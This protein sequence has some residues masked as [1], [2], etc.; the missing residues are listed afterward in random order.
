MVFPII[1]VLSAVVGIAGTAASIKAQSD[2]ASAQN[3]AIN[4]QISSNVNAERIRRAN[5]AFQRELIK[6][7]TQVEM[8][9]NRQ[10]FRNNRAQLQ[11]AILQEQLSANADIRQLGIQQQQNEAARLNVAARTQDTAYQGREAITDA[12]YQQAQQT[13]V[14]EDITSQYANNYRASRLQQ[15]LG[16]FRGQSPMQVRQSGLTSA[17]LNSMS[18]PDNIELMRR[19]VQSQNNVAGMQAAIDYNA[20]NTQTQGNELLAQLRA[21]QSGAQINQ[22]RYGITSSRLSSRINRNNIRNNA[23]LAEANLVTGQG[24]SEAQSA[25]QRAQLAS[26]QVAG[27]SFI[28]SLASFGNA[29]LPLA[30]AFNLPSQ[31][32]VYNPLPNT[33]PSF[34]NGSIPPP[35]VRIDLNKLQPK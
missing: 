33:Q 22:A 12:I 24:L 13:T 27:P 26:Q 6:Y 21:A 19:Y 7:N 30:N 3:A 31:A 34:N 25:M 28:S 18:N 5:T 17:L 2:Q 32:P 10:E 29:A 35:P 11:N 15:Q 8:Q 9:A 1:P 23:F 4:A 14:P 20:L 16:S